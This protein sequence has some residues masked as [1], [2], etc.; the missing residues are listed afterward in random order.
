M[1]A[2][3]LILGMAISAA[4]AHAQT[5][6]PTSRV[7]A[8]EARQGLARTPSVG[9]GSYE[10]GF[11]HGARSGRG[12]QVW[13]NG[14]RYEGEW[15]ADR[16]HGRG[17]Y[18]H[19]DGMRYEGQWRHGQKSGHGVLTWPNGN[20]F[21]GEWRNGRPDGFGELTS[22]GGNVARGIWRDGCF[23][24]PDGRLVLIYR[25]TGECR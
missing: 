19:A 22:E 24:R 13:P 12:V 5:L 8:L 25:P 21:E 16:Q 14:D 7:P 3:T 4:A 20:R 2:A 9:G 11:V 6:P 1:R 23:R 17:T 18:I 10:G 15:Q